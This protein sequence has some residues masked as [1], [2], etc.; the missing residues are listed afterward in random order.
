MSEFEIIQKKGTLEI[1]STL[2]KFGGESHFTKL[3]ENVNISVNTLNHRIEQ[4]KAIGYI[5]EYME[6]KFQPK[7]II[8]LTESG[9]VIAE[10][11]RIFSQVFE[12]N[13]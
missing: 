7:R 8:Y 5:K 6:E 4:M 3:R 1:L 11:A 12:K 2:V 13:Q 10:S 9:K